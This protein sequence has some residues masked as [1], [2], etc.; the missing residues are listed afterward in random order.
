M[1]YL[2]ILFVILF[3]S[4][5]KYID[6]ADIPLLA[7]EKTMLE[8]RGLVS[9]VVQGNN[10][11]GG[12]YIQ[13]AR[14]FYK[15]SVFVN[16]LEHVSV[17]DEVLLNAV[18]IE[19]NNETQLDN[20][21]LIKILSHNRF[22]NV[23]KISL[24]IS[25]EQWEELEGC[26]VEIDDKLQISDSYQF[27]KYGQL[28]LSKSEL[29]QETE[30]F[31]AQDDSLEITDLRLQQDLN[32]IYID[33]LSDLKFPQID[34]L[35]IDPFKVVVGAKCSNIKGFVSQFN[36]TYKLRLVNDLVVEQ[37]IP[38]NLIDLDSDLKIMNFNLYNLFNG[39]GK[40]EGFP[41]ARGAKSY[42]AY[43]LQL[44]KLSSAIYTVDPDI[45]AMMELE[46][47]G[48]HELSSIQQFCDYLN[49]H[50]ERQYEIA[51]TLGVIGDYPIKT[52]IIY[53]PSVVE[54]KYKAQY[55][56]H[57]NFSRPSLSQRFIYKDSLEF[58]L[59]ANHFKSKGSRNATGLDLDQKD[60]QASYNYKRTLQAKTLLDIIDSLYFDENIIVLGDFNAY[61]QED[62]IQALQST[63]L[64]RLETVNYSYIYK[65]KN[66]S[67][68]HIFVS[69]NFKDHIDQVQ[70]WNIN[71]IY[72]SWINYSY[73]LADSSYF[74]SSDHNPM[75]IGVTGYVK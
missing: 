16:S 20:V 49:K 34:S 33:D 10:Q 32:S 25:N 40:K 45:L 75:I 52:G 8:I 31:D 73:N 38:T 5:N 62:P 22:I 21:E 70:T 7:K 50:G 37:S 64:N 17:G 3:C 2:I 72:P 60:G 46:N 42:D 4:C 9:G 43:Q 27:N 44:K 56:N 12:F 47:D 68:D 54:T 35:Y 69:D 24:P 53:D 13:D 26:L 74:R 23:E 48:E 57:P 71:S 65:G 66:G 39:N 14:Y 61:S 1:K 30:L 29:I 63:N 11:L 36:N 19:K 55:H 59:C 41:S 51:H 28:L 67:L 58:V 18:I 15:K 6:V